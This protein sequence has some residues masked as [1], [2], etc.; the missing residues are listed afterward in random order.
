MTF[1]VLLLLLL[2]TLSLVVALALYIRSRQQ[3]AEQVRTNHLLRFT[4]VKHC[5]ALAAYFDEG[6]LKDKRVQ[7]GVEHDLVVYDRF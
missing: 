3:L 4:I 7:E 2:L 6:K 5:L 1:G